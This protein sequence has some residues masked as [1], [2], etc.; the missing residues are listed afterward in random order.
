MS[1]EVR[2]T[3]NILKLHEKLYFFPAVLMRFGFA[4]CLFKICL[5]WTT[6]YPEGLRTFLIKSAKTALENRWIQNSNLVTNVDIYFS[7]SFD[8]QTQFCFEFSDET[9][10]K[11]DFLENFLDLEGLDA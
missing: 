7:A 4:R 2:Q 1:T 10:D 8:V 11:S 6:E 5:F 9:K 3:S